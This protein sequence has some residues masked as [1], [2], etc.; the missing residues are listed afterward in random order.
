VFSTSLFEVQVT[1]LPAELPL[2]PLPDHV[3]LPGLPT[4]YRVFEERY[5]LLVN[6]LLVRHP[7]ERWLAMPCLTGD[8]RERYHERPNFE[9]VAT[10]AV[11]LTCRQADS[12]YCH[13]LIGG[14]Q[15]CHLDEVASEKA[16]RVAHSTLRED[17]ASSDLQVQRGI[18]AL[19]QLSLTM[20]TVLGPAAKILSVLAQERN[21]PSLFVDRLATV[22][23]H[24]PAQRQALLEER[25]LER[26]I[27]YL[28]GAMT[29][30]IASASTGGV[31]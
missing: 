9:P 24:E 27:D 19:L 3:L 7:S 10:A 14:V 29:D 26:R 21:Q 4:P 17:L 16:Y 18:D 2:F 8:W 6:D 30:I 23:L 13:V 5:L 25:S 28:L 11:L 15:R 22:V 12:G 31:H 20:L 1:Q